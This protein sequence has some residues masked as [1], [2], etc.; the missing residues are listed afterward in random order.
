M[1]RALELAAG[2]PWL[3]LPE[4]LDTLLA[5]ADRQGNPEALEAK[6]GRE[7][8]N[9]RTVTV[10]DGVAIVPVTGPIFRYANLFTRVSG[11]TV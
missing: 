11:A 7:L 1:S 5:I 2:R 6:L 8:D 3:M 4:A 10:R 9:S